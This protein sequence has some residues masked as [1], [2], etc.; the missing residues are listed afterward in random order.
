MLVIVNIGNVSQRRLSWEEAV[1][2]FNLSRTAMYGR[3]TTLSCGTTLTFI[4]ET[5]RVSNR[6][7]CANLIHSIDVTNH[8][9]INNEL[10][11]CTIIVH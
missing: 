2:E 3:E 1:A 11:N 10:S 8:Y 9:N 6:G 7:L 4:R 5:A